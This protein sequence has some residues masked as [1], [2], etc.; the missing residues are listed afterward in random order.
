MG[1]RIGQAGQDCGVREIDQAITGRAICLR[2]G[3]DADN[4][5][6]F[7]HDGLVGESLSAADIQQLSGVNDDTLDAG[8]QFPG[9]AAKALKTND[10]RMIAK[11][12]LPGFF[13]FAPR[14]LVWPYSS[15]K[16]ET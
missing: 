11:K 5:A 14:C 13:S 9:P 10:K 7:D 1:V 12:I 2:H 15:S 3:A 4:L 8:R 6:A 16:L